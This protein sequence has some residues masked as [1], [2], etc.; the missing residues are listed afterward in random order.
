VGLG[1]EVVSIDYKESGTDIYI[2]TFWRESR[3]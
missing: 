2:T 1:S 3:E